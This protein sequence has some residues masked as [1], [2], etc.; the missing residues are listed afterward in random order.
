MGNDTICNMLVSWRSEKE[1]GYGKIE[2][3]ATDQQQR[4]LWR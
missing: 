2:S 1:V 3:A 4:L